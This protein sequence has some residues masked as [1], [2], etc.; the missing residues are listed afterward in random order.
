MTQR[1]LTMRSLVAP[2]KCGPAEYEIQD[3]PTPTITKPDQVI[4][5]MHAVSM[6]A[7][8]LLSLSGALSII[9]NPEYVN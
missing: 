2:R 3:M 7:G 4:I 1:P 5:R 9:H 6:T 8:E